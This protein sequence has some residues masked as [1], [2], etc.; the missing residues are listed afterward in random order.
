MTIYRERERE[1]EKENEICFPSSKTLNEII[2]KVEH[3]KVNINVWI[4]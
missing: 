4:I 1:G 2:L 3:M